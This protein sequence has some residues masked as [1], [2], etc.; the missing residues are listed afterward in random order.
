[1]AANPKTELIVVKIKIN[2]I[3]LSLHYKNPLT[4]LHCH[5]TFLRT[6]CI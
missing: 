4:I 5:K 3:F 6:F 2:L 1:M